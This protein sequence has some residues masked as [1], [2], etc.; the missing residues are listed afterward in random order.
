LNRL[1]KRRLAAAIVFLAA[2]LLLALV[3]AN[4]VVRYAI[5]ISTFAVGLGLLRRAL[6]VE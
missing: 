4:P 5:G 3:F 6:R 1:D 2:G